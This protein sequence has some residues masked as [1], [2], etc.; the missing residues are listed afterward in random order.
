MVLKEISVSILES[1]DLFV[2]FSGCPRLIQSRWGIFPQILNNPR[3]VVAQNRDKCVKL[4]KIFSDFA[5]MKR[6]PT[7][8]ELSWCTP[9]CLLVEEIK[10]LVCMLR[11]RELIFFTDVLD[12]EYIVSLENFFCKLFFFLGRGRFLWCR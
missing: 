8:A 10:E 6:Q 2:G 4:K 5:D 9:L 12:K 3:V 1:I 7:R 11:D